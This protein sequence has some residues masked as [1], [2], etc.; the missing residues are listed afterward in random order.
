MIRQASFSDVDVLS[1]LTYE[2]WEN[3]LFALLEPE[4]VSSFSVSWFAETLKLDIDCDVCSVMVYEENNEVLGYAAGKYPSESSDFEILRLYVHPKAQGLGIG[5][6]LF[7]EMK[8][9]S[10]ALNKSRMILWALL[11]AKNNHFYISQLPVEIIS[12]DIN[13][14]GFKYSGVGYVYSS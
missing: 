10:I 11:G 5:G 6:K 7:S 3:S 14:F 4:I 8:A 2:A 13:M 1:V 9:Q 12:R